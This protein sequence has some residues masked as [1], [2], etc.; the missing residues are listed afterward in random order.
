MKY[1]MVID[2]QRCVGCQTCT[3]VC[4]AEHISPP[5]ILRCYV[6]KKEIGE[7]P[8]T[9]RI[10][11]PMLC[12]QCENPPCEKVCPTGATERLPNGIVVVHQDECIGCH[13]CATACPYGSRSFRKDSQGYF[14]GNDLTP[15]EKIGYESHPVGISE[16]CDFCIGRLNQG[17]EPACVVSCITKARIFGTLDELQTLINQRNGFQ[18]LPEYGTN[19]SV[20]YLP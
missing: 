20:Y 10:N 13:A 17:L 9:R 3:V 4:K 2:L 5:D 11:L 16:K 6:M 14:P 19:P 12:M 18:L 1:A 7:Y 15:L 8:N